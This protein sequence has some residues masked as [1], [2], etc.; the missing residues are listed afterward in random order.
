[1]NEDR[2]DALD[3]QRFAESVT[4]HLDN[5]DP[6]AILALQGSWGRGKTDVLNRVFAGF[7]KRATTNRAPAPLWLDPW[8]YGTP[9]LIRPVVL[10]LLKEV[11]PEKWDKDDKLRM[12]A[13]TLVQAG[14]A[15]L[16]KAMTLVTP[17]PIGGVLGEAEKPVSDMLESL[18]NRKR[19]GNEIDPDPVDAMAERFRDLVDRYLEMFGGSG[20]L[21]ICVD[22]L[23]RCLPDQQIAMLEAIYF[24]TTA[25]AHCAFLI[26]LDPVLVQQAAITHYRTDG[27]D[28]N[29]Y[30]DKLFD[31]RLR[32]PELTTVSV[33]E[34]LH[35]ELTPPTEAILRAGLRVDGDEVATAFADVFC[36]PELRNPRL[37]HRVCERLKLLALSNRND[38]D[39]RVAGPGRLTAVVTWCAIADRWPEVRQILQDSPSEIWADNLRIVCFTYGFTDIYGE[40][41][42]RTEIEENLLRYSNVPDRLPGRMR[43][44]DLGEFLFGQVL[45]DPGFVTLLAE[46][47]AAM[48][49]FGL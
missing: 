14:N 9:D 41:R 13:R 31:I 4:A 17:A 30:L 38:P 47:D 36:L 26:A 2:L 21:L 46:A 18:F 44:P 33:Q 12:A 49:T 42:P 16:F 11:P 5:L 43:Q 48:I 34:L 29:K 25:Q 3:H 6:G 28:A 10:K 39:P 37:I 32:L 8:R 22:D 40:A 1:M 27:F 15:M 24:L 23:D 19:A 7:A 45:A 35:S 20:R